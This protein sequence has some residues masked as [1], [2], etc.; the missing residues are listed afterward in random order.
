MCQGCWTDYGRPAIDNE[1]VRR[2]VAAVDALYEWHGAGGGMHI[3]TDDWNVE[4]DSVAFCRER[5]QRDG[6]E[7]ERQCLEAVALLTVDERASALA[8]KWGMVKRWA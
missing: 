2:A 1:R 3:V 5:I 8:M 6:D 4:D 7:R